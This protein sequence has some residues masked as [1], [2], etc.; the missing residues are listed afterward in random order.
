M[1]KK[2]SF[3]KRYES[4]AFFLKLTAIY[5]LVI[6]YMI[7]MND[8]LLEKNSFTVLII[9]FYI[10]PIFLC[11][12]LGLFLEVVLNRKKSTPPYK[13][14]RSYSSG[15]GKWMREG[16]LKTEYRGSLHEPYSALPDPDDD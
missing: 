12:G 4:I 6:S 13:K 16:S 8:S 14:T 15:S 3:F 10:I 2:K 1:N 7:L 9:W 11:Y 5:I